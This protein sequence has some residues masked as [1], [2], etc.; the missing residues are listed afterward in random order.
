MGTINIDG[1]EIS[2]YLREVIGI[3]LVTILHGTHGELIKV[4][5]FRM[6]DDIAYDY[7]YCFI[8]SLKDNEEW[9]SIGIYSS[10]Y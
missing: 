1:Q 8:L 10:I 9:K 7:G 3:G 5:I 2:F 6:P 4:K